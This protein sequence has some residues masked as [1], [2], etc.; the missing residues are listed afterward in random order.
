MVENSTRELVSTVRALHPGS[1]VEVLRGRR[2][3]RAAAWEYVVL[4][5]RRAPR[6]LVPAAPAS[7]TARAVRRFS[8]DASYPETLRRLTVSTMV[9]GPGAAAFADRVV[10]R[11]RPGGS[12]AEYLEELLGVPVAFSIGI[13]TPRVN[14]KPVL[15]LFGPTGATLAFAK[16][17]NSRQAHVDVTAEAAALRHLAGRDWTHL[18]LPTVLHHGTWGSMTLLVLSAL[19]TSPLQSPRARG[20]VPTAAMGELAGAFPGETAPVAELQWLERQRSAADWLSKSRHRGALVACIERLRE[21]SGSVRWSTGAWHGDWTPWNMARAGS[22][23]HVW[24]WER[25]E[26][27]VPLGL[28]RCHFLVNAATRSGGTSPATIRAG[29]AAAGATPD[30][31]GSWGHALGALYLIAVA[32]RYL[33]LTEG[34]RGPYIAARAE[35]VLDTLVQWT[36]A[37]RDLPRLVDGS[38]THQ[39]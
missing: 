26:T 12:F 10:V 15:Q 33:P 2:R 9:R 31:P 1:D 17:G 6:L 34:P 16:L 20:R 5:H 4:P 30:T 14:R 22:R 13:G 36:F 29:L 7:A 35:C 23:V 11:G 38:T 27:D 18:G 24:D 21:T 25:F 8:A 3:D 19:T 37:G 39:A 28:D 32:S